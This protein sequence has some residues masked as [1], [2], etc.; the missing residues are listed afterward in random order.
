MNG[1]PHRVAQWLHYLPSR[2][3][4][5]VVVAVVVHELREGLDVVHRKNPDAT[6]HNTPKDSSWSPSA[7]Q[8]KVHR[9]QEA[10]V[11]NSNDQLGFPDR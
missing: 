1:E 10:D 4:T 5:V 11:D 6:V 9:E 2:H 3:M 7:Q 8:G